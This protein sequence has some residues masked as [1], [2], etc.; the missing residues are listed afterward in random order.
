[1]L[2]LILGSSSPYRQQVL[3][4]LGIAFETA[5]PD[6]NETPLPDET[7]SALVQRLSEAKALAVAANHPASLVIGSDQVAVL[8]GRIIGK[9]NDHTNAVQQLRNASGK[10]VDFMTGLCL[11]NSKTRRKQTIV[12][13]FS[14]FFRTL[15]QDQIERYL[16]HDQP[17]NCA[18][19][20]RSESLGIALFTRMQGD[21]P[22]A[23]MGLPLIR[24]IDML[25]QEG[26]VIP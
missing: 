8:E 9:P 7:P 19:S 15:T 26:I 21:D 11:Y 16:R 17:Y 24:L 1:M 20:F 5:V 22:N 25:A 23:L 14:V 3:L 13:P 12:E 2:K 10:R 6:V 18:G 4:K